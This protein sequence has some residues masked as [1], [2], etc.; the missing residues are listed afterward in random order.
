[1]L[2]SGTYIVY[3]TEQNDYMDMQNKIKSMAEQIELRMNW[4]LD[5][6][7]NQID[8][9][10]EIYILDES[11]KVETKTTGTLAEG[12]IVK[13][14]VI[15]RA[16]SQN[17]SATSPIKH[18]S[19]LIRDRYIDHARVI[20][21]D[22]GDISNIIYIRASTKGIYRNV[23]NIMKT[24]CIGL[25]IAMVIA[26]GCGIVFANMIT[27]PIKKLTS[28]SKKLAQGRTISHI[29]VEAAD[30]IGELTQ[31]FNYMA[32]QLVASMAEVSSE[33]NKLE[34]IFEHMADGVMA[35]NTQGTLI[36]LNSVCYEMLGDKAKGNN[37]EDIFNDIQLGTSFDKILLGEVD[38][39]NDDTLIVDDKYLKMYF[40]VYLN[41]TG[42]K[43]GIVV[44]IQDITKQ[45]KLD[46]MRKEFV[47]N[48]SH[49]LRTPLTTVKSYTE[50]LLDGAIEDKEMAVHFLGV[51]EKEADRMTDLVQDLL[52]L[53][54]IDNKQIQLNFAP[55]NLKP[56]LE[57][58]LEAQ[59]IHIIKKEHRLEV[60]YDKT[61]E[62]WVYGD[63]VRVRQILHNI[64]SNAIKYSPEPGVIEATLKVVDGR[65]QIAVS[66]TGM[67][68]PKEDIDRIFERF[69]RVDKAR[70]RAMGGTGLGLSIAKELMVLHNG[71]IYVESCYGKG[72]NVTLDFPRNVS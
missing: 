17:K 52:E 29:P 6:L 24:I 64:L 36:H 61:A 9:E 53:S 16:I 21:D 35:F 43:D 70:S 20:K 72:T 31:S 3:S 10:Y 57:E 7:K 50:T 1:M 26:G 54:R 27:S 49:E 55:I 13:E 30:E 14:E 28:N 23:S 39:R 11:G 59:Y 5:E 22:D 33:K 42:E 69:Y 34:K 45:Y 12:E 38:K 25:V 66:D 48:V 65:I 18:F 8:E 4:N 41:A 32:N 71:D 51:M 2:V 19:I 58:V 60:Q 46:S 44:V 56:L 62:Y 47:A 67:G 63:I 68:I 15:I 37:F 40:D